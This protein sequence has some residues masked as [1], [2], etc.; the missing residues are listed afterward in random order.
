MFVVV[1]FTP[2]RWVRTS[3][4]MTRAAATREVRR[5]KRVAP[6]GYTLRVVPCR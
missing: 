6:P 1:S 3:R 2:D 5:I 4:R